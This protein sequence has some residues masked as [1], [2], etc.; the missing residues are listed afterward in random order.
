MPAS[1][2]GDHRSR[3]VLEHPAG[4]VAPGPRC[5]PG[6]L[7][8]TAGDQRPAEQGDQ[9]PCHPVIGH[10]FA[11]GL[12]LVGRRGVA[13]AENRFGRESPGDQR[14]ADALAGHRVGHGGGI[15]DEHRARS[16]QGDP[17]DSRRDGP[18]LVG[19]LRS[20]IGTED[21]ADVGAREEIGPQRLHV[22]HRVMAAPLYAEADVGPA[23]GEGERPRVPRQEV[24]LEP[25]DEFVAGAGTDVLEVLTEGMPFAPIALDG[26]AERLSHGRP[27]AVRGDEVLGLDRAEAVEFDGDSGVAG[28]RPRE[29]HAFLDPS[30]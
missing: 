7:E 1:G 5:C 2:G 24:L 3:V 16:R 13:P 30:P 21:V 12:P 4:E 9:Q 6:Q 11:S 23:V 22:P 10:E 26:Q 20:G 17:S 29:C 18:G 28:C 25:D 19:L 14:L 8:G 15:A 27:H